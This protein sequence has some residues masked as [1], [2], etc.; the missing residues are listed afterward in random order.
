M[1][2][3][4]AATRLRMLTSNYARIEQGHQNLTIETLVRMANLLDVAVG[5]L[6][7]APLS[8]NPAK[9]GRPRK[10]PAK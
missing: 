3:E 8:A 1:T 4:E 10:R 6:F 7:V 2:Q 9:P 5:D